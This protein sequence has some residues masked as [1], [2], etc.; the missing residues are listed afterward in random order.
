MDTLQPWLLRL[1]NSNKYGGRTMRTD[2]Q[3]VVLYDC[4]VWTD[5]HSQ[6]VKAKYPE[7]DIAITQSLASLSGFIVVFRMHRDRSL[8][9]WVTATGVVFGLLL[10]TARQTMLLTAP[11]IESFT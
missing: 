10:L 3:T 5:A 8:Y 9:T 7:C 1:I 4:G 11:S 6:A 2:E